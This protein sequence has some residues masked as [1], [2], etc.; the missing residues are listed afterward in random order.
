MKR[1]ISVL[2]VDDDEDVRG[3]LRRL[4]ESFG[5]FV[6]E[7]GNGTD[8]VCMFADRRFDVIFTDFDMPGM[9]GL[10]LSRKI[11]TMNRTG[12]F[13][14]VV[15][16]SG[17][18]LHWDEVIA[19]GVFDF[20]EKPVDLASLRKVFIEAASAAAR[21]SAGKT[22]ADKRTRFFAAGNKKNFGISLK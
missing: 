14:P 11:R 19:A 4:F 18:R 16:L 1:N 21:G 6:S 13:C 3:I 9:D 2:V 7:A 20:I 10:A 5:A 12:S 22:P 15:L 17:H 8:A